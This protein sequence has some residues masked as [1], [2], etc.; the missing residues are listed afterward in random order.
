MVRN[1]PGRGICA[2]SPN[3]ACIAGPRLGTEGTLNREP[4]EALLPHHC[5]VS[6]AVDR[7]PAEVCVVASRREQ[8]QR[9]QR[10]ARGL[11][12]GE[13]APLFAEVDATGEDGI[14]TRVDPD[15]ADIPTDVLDRSERSRGQ[16]DAALGP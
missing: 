13:D 9:A 8:T 10:A 15:L 2:N 11:G 12:S 3:D 16:P 4:S 1:I 7:D 14:A 5:G 6:C